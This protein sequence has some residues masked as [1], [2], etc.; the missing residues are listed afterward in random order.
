MTRSKRQIEIDIFVFFFFVSAETKFT[1][2]WNLILDEKKPLFTIEKF[3]S[4]ASEEGKTSLNVHDLSR[5]NAN[6]TW[7]DGLFPLH[8]VSSS[9]HCAA[10]L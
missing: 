2:F 3:L 4:Q 10:A 8:C 6:Q 7:N 5:V 1:N 9:A